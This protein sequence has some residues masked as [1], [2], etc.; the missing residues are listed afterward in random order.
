MKRLCFL[1]LLTFLLFPVLKAQEVMSLR[2][3]IDVAVQNN[4]QLLLSDIDINQSNVDVQSSKAARWPNLN[5]NTSYYSSFGRRI[6]PTTNTFNNQNFGN[7]Q[8]NVSSDITLFSFNRISNA[9]R[10][11]EYSL[12][13]SEANKAQLVNDISLSVAQAYLIAL[14]AKENLEVALKS[15]E[16]TNSQLTLTDKL[17][18][19]GSKNRN[20]RLEIVAQ[21]AQNEVSIIAAEN[22]I[23]VGLLNLKQLMMVDPS[24]DIDI[25]APDVPVPVEAPESYDYETLVATAFQNQPQ[26]EAWESQLQAAILGEKIAKSQGLPS[27]GASVSLGSNYST[28]NQRVESF[29]LE[30]QVLSGAKINGVPA[31]VSIPNLTPNLSNNPY[32]S[33]LNEN[34]GLGAGIG[35][36]IPIYNRNA[37]KSAIQLARLNT[38]RVNI[39]T[40]QARQTLRNDVMKALSDARAARKTLEAS[41]RNYEA[42]EAANVDVGKRFEI[43]SANTFELISAKNSL[44]NAARNV[45]INKYDYTFKMKVLDYYTGKEITL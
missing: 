5:A 34:L 4:L 44:D 25:A 23:A 40:I 30:D 32:F 43:G 9:I 22:D 42:L 15:Y 1:G 33:Q 18:E 37:A 6:D 8:Y 3:C 16:Q 10:Q 11:S 12:K 19:A 31:E 27:I 14:V 24:I 28:L 45:I 29:T 17:I 13:A 39:Q 38:E 35:L 20:S 7:Q 36:S 2:Q 41:Q 21:L 26:F